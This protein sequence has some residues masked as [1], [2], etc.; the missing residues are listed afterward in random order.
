MQIKALLE[1]CPNEVLSGPFGRSEPAPG[2]GRVEPVGHSPT[3]SGWGAWGACV[4][5][6][7]RTNS[8]GQGGG[9]SGRIHDSSQGRL[10]RLANERQEAPY[11]PRAD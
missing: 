3:G 8:L 1:A 5:P 9:G 7:A 6:A 10:K 11:S 4:A 2:Q